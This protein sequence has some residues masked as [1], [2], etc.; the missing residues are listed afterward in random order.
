MSINDIKHMPIQERM[1]LMEALWD[2]FV[3]DDEATKSPLWHKEILDKRR[4]MIDSSD[5]KTYTLDEL[6]KQCQ[7]LNS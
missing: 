2:S 6:K 3:H 7:T 1:Q 4:E 5:V